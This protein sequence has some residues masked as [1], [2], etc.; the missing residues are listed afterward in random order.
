MNATYEKKE[1]DF[2]QF[3]SIRKT[4]LLSVSQP[5]DNGRSVGEAVGEAGGEAA[6]EAAA[7]AEAGGE[8]GGRGPENKNVK[9]EKKKN[10]GT[11]AGGANTNLYGKKFEGKTENELRLLESGF[12]KIRFKKSTKT[13]PYY[14][15]KKMDD[16]TIVYVSQYG[17]RKYMK[18]K[19]NIDIYRRPDEAYII[20]YAD[21][22]ILVQILEKKEQR[23]GGTVADKLWAGHGFKREYELVLGERF[24]VIYAFCVSSFFKEKFD[25]KEQ[26]YQ[27]LKIINR[28]DNITVLF[29]DDENYFE[30][31]DA[32]LQEGQAI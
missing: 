8:A 23:V 19:N 14:L 32:W 12:I 13:T 30:T 16:R 17:L 5:S 24:K 25:S 7:E 26:R 31:L 22:R 4:P 11:G 29:G 3:F 18:Q 2:K 28:E 9:P 10:K 1:F 27:K 6:A 21:G 15:E 20:E